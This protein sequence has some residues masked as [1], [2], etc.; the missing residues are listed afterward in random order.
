MDYIKFFLIDGQNFVTAIVH[1]K[2]AV[3]FI[4]NYCKLIDL[5]IYEI[6]C[7]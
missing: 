6:Y 7:F 1:T 4:I 2:F 5:H 3:F